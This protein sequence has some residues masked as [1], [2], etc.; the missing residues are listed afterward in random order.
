MGGAAVAQPL[1]APV[2]AAAQIPP[3]PANLQQLQADTASLEQQLAAQP[4]NWPVAGKL[5]MSLI[6]LQQIPRALQVLDQILA[7]PQAGNNEMI[8][9]AQVANELNQLS[10]VE[11]ALSRLVKLSPESPEAWFD[12]AGIQAVLNQP[13]QALLSLSESLKRNSQR[14]AQHPQAPNLFTNALVD[15]K[16]NS[17]RPLPDF[18]R[19]ITQYASR[20]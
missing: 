5:V 10:R 6:Q 20:K 3:G 12:L 17:I 7:S 11:Q 1:L 15:E 16:L 4:T 9:A 14:R 13:T 19:M 2:A 18:Q 8:F